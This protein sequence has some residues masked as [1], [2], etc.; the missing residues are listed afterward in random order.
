MGRR[1][2]RARRRCPPCARVLR[3][4]RAR[5]CGLVRRAS[6]GGRQ[7]RLRPAPAP[8]RAVRKDRAPSGQRADVQFMTVH[9]TSGFH[10]R[11]RSLPEIRGFAPADEHLAGE[12]AGHH[13]AQ[14]PD[15]STRRYRHQLAHP[16][17]RGHRPRDPGGSNGPSRL[18]SRPVSL[19]AML[20]VMPASLEP[21]P[22]L[23]DGVSSEELT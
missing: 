5:H 3:S 21:P 6:R 22:D 18:F 13:E 10:I 17:A 15:L 1:V 19:P 23:P 8:T 12:L 11:H 9:F 7:G 14:R 4:A 20:V 2:R 16:G